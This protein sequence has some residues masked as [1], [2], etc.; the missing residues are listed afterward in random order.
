MRDNPHYPKSAKLESIARLSSPDQVSAACEQPPG[1]TMALFRV[2]LGV[3]LMIFLWIGALRIGT[4]GT[5]TQDIF[6]HLVREQD[7]WTLIPQAALLCLGLL[8]PVQAAGLALARAMGRHPIRT[9]V[10]ATIVLALGAKFVYHAH[11]LSMDEYAPYFQSQVFAQFRL[12]GQYPLGLVDWLVPSA[13]Q[14]VFFA[15]ARGTGEVASSY[16]PGMALLLTPFSALGVPWLLNPVIGGL[17]LIVVDRIARVLWADDERPGLAM[18]FTLA[19]PAVTVNA[20]SFYSMPA[21]LLLNATFLLLLLRPGSGRLLLAGFVGSIALVL[22]N[23]VPHLL[24]ATPFVLW[25]AAR[26]GRFRALGALALG[27]LPLVLLLGWGWSHYLREFVSA[28][29]ATRPAAGGGLSAGVVSEMLDRLLYVAAIL[30]KLPD[31]WVVE[32]RIIG[33][34]KLWIW[35]APGLVAAAVIGLWRCR[36]EKGL[37]LVLACAALLT[38]FGYFMVRFDQGHGWGYR[39][40]HSAWLLLPLFA[41]RAIEPE[42]GPGGDS[43]LGLKAYLAGCACTALLVMNVFQGALV[44]GFISRHLDQLPGAGDGRAE[45]V[46]IDFSRG[47]FRQDLV[48]NDPFLREP[49]IFFGSRGSARDTTMMNKHFPDYRQT[50]SDAR[51]SVWSSVGDGSQVGQGR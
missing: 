4:D 24:F 45:I 29:A 3:T 17:T 47:S 13:F 18:L 33:L 12:A 43:G 32:M 48:Q 14:G 23:P 35:A 38:Y 40:F 10:A 42:S 6:L 9:S 30:M 41:L 1:N 19:S 51:G 49:G 26:E 27:Y 22:H 15:I 39:Y 16:F 25:L 50:S 34:A 11:P 36:D 44:E 31:F 28:A 8:P 7:F 37:W 46:F 21:H 2:A 20:M 5:A